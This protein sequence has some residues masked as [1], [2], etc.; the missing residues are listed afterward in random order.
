M[1]PKILVP[2][3]LNVVTAGRGVNN[4]Y[5]GT[6]A[7]T[8]EQGEVPNKPHMLGAVLTIQSHPWKG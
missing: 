8:Q 4:N 7:E 2:G 1:A 5:Y 3:T 6:T